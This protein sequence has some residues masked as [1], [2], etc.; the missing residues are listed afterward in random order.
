M[1]HYHVRDW[2]SGI[3]NFASVVEGDRG[4]EWSYWI[5]GAALFDEASAFFGID[6]FHQTKYVWY[7]ILVMISTVTL[8]SWEARVLD[9]RPCRFFA[10]ARTTRHEPRCSRV[11]SIQARTP[12]RPVGIAARSLLRSRFPGI[13]VDQ[14]T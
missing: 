3:G 2:L 5:F 12:L 4:R 9:L 14:T 6:Y 11:P 1:L 7:L 13:S 10:G 8:A